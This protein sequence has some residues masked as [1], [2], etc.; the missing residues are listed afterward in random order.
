[1]SGPRAYEVADRLRGHD[2]AGWL[3]VTVVEQPGPAAVRPARSRPARDPAHD[4]DYD[5]YTRAKAAF[6]DQAGPRYQPIAR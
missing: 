5:D 4:V 3:T 2:A 1:M 6:F